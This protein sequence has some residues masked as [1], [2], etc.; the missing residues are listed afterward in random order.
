M[1]RRD[2]NLSVDIV[3]GT[4][5]LSNRLAVA[6]DGG[7]SDLTIN[8]WCSDSKPRHGR[9]TTSFRTRSH[10][11]MVDSAPTRRDLAATASTMEQNTTPPPMRV[12][13]SS[14]ARCSA[15]A[16]HGQA[17][18]TPSHGRPKILKSAVRVTPLVSEMRPGAI[19]R[20]R[21]NGAGSMRGRL[22]QSDPLR[23]SRRVRASVRVRCRYQYVVR[24]D[25]HRYP[26]RAR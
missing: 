13:S 12:F 23:G 22:P 6:C 8:D 4:G 25:C 20:C 21:R 16:I 15:T 3:L 17:R 18:K 11:S 19:R 2:H 1:I 14:P 26:S 7:R 9:R 5:Q 24:C 10:S